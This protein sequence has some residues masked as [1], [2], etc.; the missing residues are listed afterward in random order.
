MIQ[1][2]DNTIVERW[3]ARQAF[4]QTFCRKDFGR[5]FGCIMNAFNLPRSVEILGEARSWARNESQA[6]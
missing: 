3:N 5:I 6:P 1:P 2:F 4:L